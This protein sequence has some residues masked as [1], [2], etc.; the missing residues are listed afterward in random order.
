MINLFI[1]SI[2]T[3][4]I[5]LNKFLGIT[6]TKDKSKILYTSIISVFICIISS[7][8]NY[9]IYYHLLVPFKITY[10]ET[11]MF[12]LSITIVTSIVM[13]LIKLLITNLYN[14]VEDSLPLIITNSL[15]LGVNLLVITNGYN[16]VQTLVFSVGSSIGFLLITYLFYYLDDELSKRKVMR[17]FKGYPILLIT[18]A[19]IFM[20]ID[21][22]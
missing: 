7:L 19:I 21:R 10:I 1:G 22:F 16:L 20:I 14:K 3:S 9:L 8:I 13:L 5:V 12:I 18:L 6:L 11:I 17:S 2:L 4:N 15:I